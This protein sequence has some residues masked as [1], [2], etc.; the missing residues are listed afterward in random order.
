[1]HLHK[2]FYASQGH[3]GR[4]SS[5]DYLDMK[6]YILVAVMLKPLGIKGY[7]SLSHDQ[8]TLHMPL[9]HHA[10]MLKSNCS[11]ENSNIIIYH[12]LLNNSNFINFTATYFGQYFIYFALY[13]YIYI[14]IY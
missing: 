3:P 5:S 1:M 9:Y 8:F 2:T 6:N 13:I 7:V 10:V 12:N 11:N 14:Y 4:V